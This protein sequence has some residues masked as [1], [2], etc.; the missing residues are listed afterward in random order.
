LVFSKDLTGFR[1]RRNLSGLKFLITANMLGRK[2]QQR[3]MPRAFDR[4]G[5]HALMPRARADLAARFD[6]AALGH[7]TAQLIGLFIVNRFD[8]GFAERAHARGADSKSSAALTAITVVAISAAARFAIR[9][10]GGTAGRRH[11]SSFFSHCFLDLLRLTVER[12]FQ[13]AH[14][15]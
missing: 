5:Q 7:V 13:A 6:L 12:L 9:S 14:A 2:G 4:D 8:L 3:D 1:Q 11:G 10:A 15:G